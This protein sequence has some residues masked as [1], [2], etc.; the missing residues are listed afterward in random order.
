MRRYEYLR[1]LAILVVLSTA[2]AGVA[3]AGELADLHRQSV[4]GLPAAPGAVEE[5]GDPRLM[6]V[7]PLPSREPLPAIERLGFEATRCRGFCEAFTVIFAA[8]GTFRYVGEA[9]VERLGEHTG[10]VGRG[11]LEM[12]MRYVEEI[13]YRGLVPTYASSFSD[14]QTTYT[15]V[16]YGEDGAAGAEDIKVVENQGGEAPATVWALGRLL[17]DLLEDADWD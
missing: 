6:P 10:S 13:D 5:T 9:N 8:D 1:S 4:R 15:M 12:V 17:V 14:F 3:L 7:A 2:G 11:A 16:D